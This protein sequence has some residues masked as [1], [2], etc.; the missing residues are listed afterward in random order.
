MFYVRV[1]VCVRESNRAFFCWKS[2]VESCVCVCVSV[3]DRERESFKRKGCV[4]VCLVIWKISER[5]E[6]KQRYKG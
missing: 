1:S 6:E 5:D 4:C 2:E 3:C